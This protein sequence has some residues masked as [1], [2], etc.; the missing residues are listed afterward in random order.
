MAHETLKL[1]QK[2]TDEFATLENYLFVDTKAHSYLQVPLERRS[3]CVVCSNTY[4]LQGI[5]FVIENSDILKN[6]KEKIS[7][8]FNI[9]PGKMVLSSSGRDLLNELSPVKGLLA[10]SD[11]LYVLSAEL[12]SPLRL[13][14]SFLD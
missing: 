3:N 2:N 10:G 6:L 12:P 5:P 14:I 1:L 4:R 9:D 7:L 11:S 8:Q 13:K